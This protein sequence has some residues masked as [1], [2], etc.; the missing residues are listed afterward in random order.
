MK[1]AALNIGA[2]N[3]TWCVIT[4]YVMICYTGG[5][6]WISV[7]LPQNWRYL[8][9]AVILVGKAIRSLGNTRNMIT[10]PCFGENIRIGFESLED[11]RCFAHKENHDYT[12][13]DRVLVCHVMSTLLRFEI[14]FS[15]KVVCL[16]L[17]TIFRFISWSCKEQMKH[18]C[19]RPP[20]TSFSVNCFHSLHP[21]LNPNAQAP[22]LERLLHS[23]QHIM[24]ILS[25]ESTHFNLRNV[26]F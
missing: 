4:I 19:L 8:S 3:V 10:L 7:H 18:S 20:P 15:Q 25:L 21:N 1:G 26:S 12:W 9:S 2:S 23:G 24:S 14:C 6:P 13:E 11:P 22:Q 5:P 17:W 16:D